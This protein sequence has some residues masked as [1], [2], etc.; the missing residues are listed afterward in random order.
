[1]REPFREADAHTRRFYS[2]VFW[3]VLVNLNAVRM[4]LY[5]TLLCETDD[6]LFAQRWRE[7]RTKLINRMRELK[8][9]R[10]PEEY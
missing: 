4:G 6:P 1:M 5:D 9:D 10:P 7:D 3:N 2:Y 8:D